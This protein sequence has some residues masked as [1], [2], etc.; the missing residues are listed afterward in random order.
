MLQL[1]VISYLWLHNRPHQKLVA[2]S[3]ILFYLTMLWVLAGG[4]FCSH[5]SLAWQT[6]SP[7]GPQMA[8]LTVSALAGTEGRLSSGALPAGAPMCA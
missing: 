6:G 8:S 5:G 2:E 1:S 7:E 4:F 3:N